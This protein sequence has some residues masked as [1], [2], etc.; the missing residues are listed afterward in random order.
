MAFAVRIV[1]QYFS[2]I[3]NNQNIFS[4]LNNL[5]SIRKRRKSGSAIHS[6]PGKSTTHWRSLFPR[7][8]RRWRPAVVVYVVHAGYPPTQSTAVAISIGQRPYVTR[9]WRWITLAE[10]IWRLWRLRAEAVR[11][12]VH[13]AKVRRRKGL[14]RP[15]LCRLRSWARLLNINNSITKIKL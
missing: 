3:Q 9:I 4:G 7:C 8:F 13:V 6:W 5:F 12:R 2:V 15:L 1:T 11:G 10:S 14:S